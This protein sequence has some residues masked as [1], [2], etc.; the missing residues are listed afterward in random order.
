[1]GIRLAEK[2]NE[3]VGGERWKKIMVVEN[4]VH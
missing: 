4:T 3:L 1:V 2:Y